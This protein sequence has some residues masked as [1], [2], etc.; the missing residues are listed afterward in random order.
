MDE[1]SGIF[2]NL[3]RNNVIRACGRDREIQS[4][5]LPQLLALL[6]ADEIESLPA[7]RPHQRYPLHCFLAQ[8]GAMALLAAGESTLPRDAANWRDLLRGLT[9]DF[10]NEE[11]WALVVDDL[12]KPALLQPPVPEVTWEA[13]KETE[14]T[15]DSLDMLVTSKN[16]DLKAARLERAAA[17]QWLY[18]LITLQT[19][20]GFLGRGNYGISRMN[21]GFA[22]R[23]FIGLAPATGGWGAHIARDI[24][25]LV[26]HRA[27]II[28]D[29]T[30]HKPAGGCRLLWLEPWDGQTSFDPRQLDPYYVEICRRVRLRNEN[31]RIV[32][33]LERR[34]AHQ[35]TQS[36]TPG[37]RLHAAHRRS[38]D[39]DREG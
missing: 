20:E 30:L 28:A 31:N 22:S 37:Q 12:S 11:P 16:H 6:I 7:L 24:H 2:G 35:P 17:E 5:T 21:G 18:A 10:P 9:P 4:V 8:V 3:L 38:M 34:G 36:Q 14:V 27:E 29:D 39:S 25:R 23:A 1:K 26:D 19:F 33:R 32:A 13:L 15:P